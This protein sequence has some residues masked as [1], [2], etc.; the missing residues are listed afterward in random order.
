MKKTAAKKVMINS[1]LVSL[2]FAVALPA[3]A[4]DKPAAEFYKGKTVEFVIPMGVGGGTDRLCRMLIP[5]LEKQMNCKI[6]PGNKTGAGGLI[7]LN[8]VWGAKNNGLVIGMAT[9]MGALWGEITESNAV[10]FETDKFNMIGGVERQVQ[11]IC[12]GK[13][14]PL[15]TFEDVVNSSKTILL[16]VPGKL[17]PMHILVVFAADAW[18]F[19]VKVIPGYKGAA[20]M[21][22]AAEGGEVDIICNSLIPSKP[23]I[24]AGTIRPLAFVSEERQDIFPDVPAI[25]EIPAKNKAGLERLRSNIWMYRHERALLMPPGVPA[26]RVKFVQDCLK[27]TLKNPEVIAAG[28]KMGVEIM[29]VEPEKYTEAFAKIKGGTTGTEKTHVKKL[30]E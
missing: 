4:A 27:E 26:E 3:F 30:L 25:F 8:Y 28:E 12:T 20:G 17:S 22:K 7:G 29:F 16:G 23:R 9:L 5:Y 6:V 18:E 19:D 24:E 1:L 2:I 13:D 15:K 11:V 21:M 10:R 14:S